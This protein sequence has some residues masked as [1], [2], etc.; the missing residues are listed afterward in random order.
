VRNEG[1][2]ALLM[3][4][5]TLIGLTALAAAGFV[6]SNTD[7]R[8]SQNHTS[9]LEA[10]LTANAG[11]YEYL[12]TQ[13][14]GETAQTYTYGTGT[15]NVSGQELLEI[16]D[17]RRLYRITALA[18]YD[19][20]EGGTATRTVSAVA[21]FAEAEVEFPAAIA[22]VP[23]L[24][25]QGGAGEID[26]NDH[27]DEGDCYIA[28]DYPVAGVLVPTGGYNQDG[29]SSVPAGDP[30]IYEM[31]LEALMELLHLDWQGVVNGDLYPDYT[32][33]ANDWP[34]FGT[35]S[36][37]DW[38]TV[39]VTGDIAVG[40]VHSGQGTLVVTGDLTMNGSFSWDGIL[41]VGGVL[42][43]NG[44]QTIEG[45]VVTGLNMLLGQTVEESHLANGNKKFRYNSCNVVF[46]K[47]AAFGGLIE[48]PGTWTE[49][50]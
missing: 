18:T 49:S 13:S 23:G 11:L 33:P 27:A 44:N 8:V 35:L 20:P 29:G 15:A 46:A 42:T 10:F 34:D 9:S 28:V 38:P 45:A 7:N 22:A 21:M 40:S 12:G 19:S 24:D 5:L 32:V 1:G 4:L 16:G 50:L 26:G 14:D 17:G 39:Q 43:S 2:F 47:Q 25:K 31:D 6:L 3:A 48:I 37:D 30:D 41:L 36:P